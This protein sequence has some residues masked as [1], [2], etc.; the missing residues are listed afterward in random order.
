MFRLSLATVLMLTIATPVLAQ[1]AG[2]V[3]GRPALTTK[4]TQDLISQREK[5]GTAPAAK[6]AAKAAAPAA[7]KEV[8]KQAQA[9]LDEA[10]KKADNILIKAKA[11]SDK[12]LQ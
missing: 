6:P 7:K 11:E 8:D 2:S 10:N 12:K 4:S 3:A 5:W 1:D 9:I